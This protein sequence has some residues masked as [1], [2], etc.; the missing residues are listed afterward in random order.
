VTSRATELKLLDAI[1]YDA[2]TLGNHEFDYTPRGLAGILAAAS[3]S[4]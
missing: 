1:G 2:T 4:R 3:G